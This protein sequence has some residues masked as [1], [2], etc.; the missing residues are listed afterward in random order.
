M[1]K[2][3]F[4]YSLIPCIKDNSKWIKDLHVRDKMIKILETDKLKFIKLK[5]F[6]FQRTQDN[7]QNGRKHFQIIY[8]MWELYPEYT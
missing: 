6:V 3:V 1:Q 2:N 4:R 7:P 5:T 8:L